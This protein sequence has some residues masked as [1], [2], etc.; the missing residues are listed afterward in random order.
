MEL[1]LKRIL[2]SDDGAA[3]VLICGNQPVCLTLEEDWRDNQKGIS[4]IPEGSYLCRRR[5]T[6]AHGETFEVTEV[7]GRTGILIHSGNTEMDTEGCILPGMEYGSIGAWDDQSKTI[8][9]QLAVLRSREAFKKFMALVGDRE[10]FAL[11]VR[12]C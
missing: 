4:C 8:E 1:V 2:F 9:P 5:T 10:L 11:H 12:N 7:P 3:G 6:A